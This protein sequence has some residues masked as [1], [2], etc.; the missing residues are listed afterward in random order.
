MP[1][2]KTFKPSFW[3]VFFF[4]FFLGSPL[5]SN[6]WIFFQNHLHST[7]DHQYSRFPRSTPPFASYSAQGIQTLVQMAKES[8]IQALAI[9]DH[10]TIHPWFDPVFTQE[11]DVILLPAM[12]WTSMFAGHASLLGF[13][14]T[15]PSHAFVPPDPRG[16][17]EGHDYQTMIQGV[18]ERG[19]LV[20]INHP[21]S[22]YIPHRWPATPYDADGIE[23]NFLPFMLPDSVID[24]WQKNLRVGRYLFL[25][26]G[27]DFHVGNEWGGPFQS[28]SLVWVKEPT[29]EALLEALREGR[30]QVLRSPSSPQIYLTMMTEKE[31][32]QVGDRVVGLGPLQSVFLEIH[33]VGNK[34]ENLEGITVHL[35]NREGEIASAQITDQA[36]S[37]TGHFTPQHPRDF[38]WAT[39]EKDSELQTLL[40][41]I[42]IESF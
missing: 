35:F 10:N 19:G 21:K 2:Q 32:F 1:P 42:Y 18:H 23:L 30:L 4:L 8:G 34:A 39:V 41:P 36:F 22:L 16:P 37:W 11:K 33:V 27:S 7:D 5:F 20:V 14:A 13:K 3:V 12:E 31:S 38:L 15:D 28:T 6:Q 29:Q 25:L 26:G 17:L 24:W 40:N 9:T